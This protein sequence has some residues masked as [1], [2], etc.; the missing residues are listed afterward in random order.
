MNAKARAVGAN[1]QFR[2]ADDS[3]PGRDRPAQ[4]V[5]RTAS[6]NTPAMSAPSISNRVVLICGSKWTNCY[7]GKNTVS[8]DGSSFLVARL[9]TNRGHVVG[10]DRSANA[11][12]TA[13]ARSQ[14]ITV[15]NVEFV[16]G[17][18]DADVLDMPEQ[19]FDAVVGQAVLYVLQDPVSLLRNVQRYVRPGGLRAQQPDPLAVRRLNTTPLPTARQSMR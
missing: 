9:V 15:E 17:D 16:Q 13:R 8:E 7:L 18:L 6:R 14:Q 10:V 19:A 2:D 5:N 3:A 12:A 4:H 11:L 1:A